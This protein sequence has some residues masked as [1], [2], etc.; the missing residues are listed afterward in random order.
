MGSRIVTGGIGD[1]VP[2][3]CCRELGANRELLPQP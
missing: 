3:P 2:L 1:E